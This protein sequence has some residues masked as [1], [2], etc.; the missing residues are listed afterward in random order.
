VQLSSNASW[1]SG[2]EMKCEDLELTLHLDSSFART[3][4]VEGTYRQCWC[5][6]AVWGIDKPI[7][8]TATR[9]D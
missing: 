3:A 4:R 6:G 1:C 2:N 7:T 8:G 5:A 9:T